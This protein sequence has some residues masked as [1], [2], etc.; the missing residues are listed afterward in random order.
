MIACASALVPAHSKR[1]RAIGF[2]C[3]SA[4]CFAVIELIG[5]HV[6]V[7]VNAYEVVWIR[8]AVHLLFMALVIAPRLRINLLR[9]GHLGLQIARGLC[10]LG[11]P[12]CFVLATQRLPLNDVW[13]GYWLAPVIGLVLSIVMLKEHAGWKHWA[14]TLVGFFGVALIMR[15]DHN[16]I[17]LVLILPIGMAL[18]FS[19]HLTLSRILRAEHPLVSLFY[20]A[21]SVFVPLTLLMPY[22]WQ[23]P[24]PMSCV[25]L[26]LIG[27]VGMVGLYAFARAS[28]LAPL[29]VVVAFAYTE[30]IWSTIISAILFHSQTTRLLFAGCL[31][32]AGS[33]GYLLWHELWLHQ[34]VP[35]SRSTESLTK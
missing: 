24:S 27:L 5:A 35:G 18:F 8:Y 34:R 9:T 31:I 25:G 3:L 7:G 4:L 11:M 20:T 30:T 16:A 28:E 12:I 29:P 6:V 10:M 15:P 26:V 22:V 17:Q 19:L 32:V 13:T 1:A 21:L 33:V 2:M 14:A 23:A